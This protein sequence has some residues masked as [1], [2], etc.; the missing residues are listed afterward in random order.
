MS[1]KKRKLAWL[2]VASMTLTS[3]SGA[4]LTGYAEEE[5]LILDEFEEEGAEAVD[6]SEGVVSEDAERESELS[7]AEAADDSFEAEEQVEE[8]GTDVFIESVEEV[9]G[10]ATQSAEIADEYQYRGFVINDK[11]ETIDAKSGDRVLLSVDVEVDGSKELEYQWYKCGEEDEKIAGATSA[12]YTTEP[13]GTDSSYRYECVVSDGYDECYAYRTINTDY[14]IIVDKESDEVYAEPNQTVTLSVK[15]STGKGKLT[16]R[17]VK[18][19]WN[20]DEYVEENVGTSPDLVVSNPQPEE[21]N[22]KCYITNGYTETEVYRSVICDNPDFTVEGGTT[23]YICPGESTELEVIAFSENATLF[24]DWYWNK[25]DEDNYEYYKEPLGTEK[26]IRVNKVGDYYCNVSDGV[27]SKTVYYSVRIEDGFQLLSTREDIRVP[28]GKCADLKV[29]ASVTYGAL[30]YQWYKNDEQLEEQTK[31]TLKTD[32]IVKE[33]QYDEYV[34]KIYNS[35]NSDDW[36]EKGEVVFRVGMEKKDGSAEKTVG[37]SVEAPKRVSVAYGTSATLSVNAK[38][39]DAGSLT[40]RWYRT[41]DEKFAEENENE[42]TFLSGNKTLSIYNVREVRRY[43][44]VVSDGVTEQRVKI[45]VGPQE[46]MDLYAEDEE[47][48]KLVPVNG[49][50]RAVSDFMRGYVY[51][52]FVPDQTG[53]W[54][55]SFKRDWWLDAAIYD[56][57]GKIFADFRD[58]MTTSL[59]PNSMTSELQAGKTY[60]IRCRGCEYED[61]VPEN[62]D[63]T[64]YSK[65]VNREIHEHTWNSGIITKQPTCVT[66]GVKTYTCSG[67]QKTRTEEIPAT[68]AHTMMTVTDRAATCGTAG[69]QHR[70][71]TVCHL[72]EAGV[73]I[74]ATGAHRYGAYTVT[75]QPTVLAAGMQVR[76]CGVCG[77]TESASIPKLTGT[78]ALKASTLPLQRKKTVELKTI[79]TGLMAGD[80]IAS[81]SSN[82]TKV[83][84]VSPTGKVTAKK[85]GKTTITITLASGVSQSVTVKVQKGAV[86]TSKISGVASKV[87]LEAGKSLALNPVITPVTTKDKLSYSSSNKKVAAV[88]KSGVI[89]SKASGKAKITI[90]SGSKKFVVTVTVPKKAP[91]GMQGVP[92]TKSLKKGKSFTI[93][94]KLLPAGA[95]AKIT[96]KSSNKKIATVN[97]KGKVI[98]KKAGTAVITVSAGGIKQTCTVTV[99]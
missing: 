2:L 95:E 8:A 27:S 69:S 40:Y 20:E 39:E 89:T 32:P 14:N 61:A 97:A 21:T 16:Y 17:W 25:Y 59:E 31:A 83:A 13:L 80:S 37:L 63:I 50:R 48:A 19:E 11:N 38:T 62:M 81:C 3:L 22:Y 52:K 56:E 70:E 66:P 1:M 53:L 90:K 29:E 98:A 49:S 7:D 35:I 47:H 58:D 86:K 79:V 67:C 6:A 18:W 26:S 88:S 43:V 24:Y 45:L 41:G 68:G 57:S 15:A 75:Q 92:V 96:Y 42:T 54:R 76:T 10:I 55:F 91:T 60:F 71:C 64:I 5:P 12:R 73:S 9:D 33:G 82:N 51:F 78:M 4:G 30:E 72:K 28:Y 34:C 74:S 87:T 77:R 46:K 44:C 84:T 93:K 85:A 23:K 99:K 65:Y 36:E 94:T